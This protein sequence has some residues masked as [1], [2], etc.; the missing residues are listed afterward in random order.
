VCNAAAFLIQRFD[1]EL[2]HVEGANCTAMSADP[3]K[4]R[5]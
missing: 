4:M 3:G 2:G 1:R 5:A